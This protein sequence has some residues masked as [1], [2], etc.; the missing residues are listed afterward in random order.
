MAEFE[1]LVSPAIIDLDE[2]GRELYAAMRDAED[3]VTAELMSL[4]AAIYQ[5]GDEVLR[6]QDADGP[7]RKLAVISPQILPVVHAAW[8]DLLDSL[9]GSRADFQG[10]LNAH[11]DPRT[12]GAGV[13]S[14]ALP[15]WI[16]HDDELTMVAERVRFHHR[17]AFRAGKLTAAEVRLIIEKKITD[18]QGYIVNAAK[19]Q[20]KGRIAEYSARLKKIEKELGAFKSLDGKFLARVLS[21]QGLRF[22]VKWPDKVVGEFGVPHL[23]LIAAQGQ[24]EQ[25][26]SRARGS[27]YGEPILELEECRLTLFR[28]IDPV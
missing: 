27:K 8:P 28:V 23:T 24:P 13:R 4:G 5:C 10:Y 22:V 18:T 19:S 1:D 11:K 17:V 15:T 25:A 6:T 14:T 2:E 26:P 12:Q 21:G 20:Q 3:A 7:R 16:G 9:R